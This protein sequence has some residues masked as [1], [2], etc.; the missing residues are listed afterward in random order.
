M[1]KLLAISII[2]LFI[3]LAFIPSFNA[4]SISKTD[5]TKPPHIRLR[6]ESWK[7]EDGKL[8]ILFYANCS[9]DE[10][11]MDRVEFIL[12]GLLIETCY[13]EPYEWIC[14][15]SQLWGRYCLYAYAYDKVGNYAYDYIY[16]RTRSLNIKSNDD[17]GCSD[18]DDYP[19]VLCAIL[20]YQRFF[21][22]LLFMKTGWD[23]PMKIINAIGV[24]YNCPDFV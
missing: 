9:D 14:N 19:L 12:D 15:Y 20:W 10:S 8:V 24:K 17:C 16:L 21:A 7:N 18:G 6:W 22:M 13:S 2:A 3:G 4:V 23:A 11:G 5:D 1:K